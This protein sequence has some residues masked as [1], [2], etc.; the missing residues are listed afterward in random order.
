MTEK[1]IENLI[2]DYLDRLPNAKF[3]KINT[4]GT[5]DNKKKVFRQKKTSHRTKGIPDIVGLLDGKFFAF[6]VK[7]P[8]RRSC[9]TDEQ[10]EF[11]KAVNDNGQIGAVVTSLDEVI[12]IIKNNKGLI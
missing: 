9:A 6:E 1:Q 12:E 8:K 3:W 2:L 7:T 10:K 5:W 4:T 11:I